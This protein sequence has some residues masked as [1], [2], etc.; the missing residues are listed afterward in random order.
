MKRKNSPGCQCCSSAGPL[1]SC[2]CVVDTSTT[3]SFSPSPII[4]MTWGPPPASL[5]N[6]RYNGAPLPT[7]WYG[8]FTSGPNT[9]QTMIACELPFGSNQFAYYNTSRRA[10]LG[11]GLFGWNTGGGAG[12][13]PFEVFTGGVTHTCSPLHWPSNSG[14]GIWTS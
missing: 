4:A 14:A 7:A 3:L 9:L 1:T 5:S 10:S 2:G 11:G 6:W 12:S 13:G 8:S